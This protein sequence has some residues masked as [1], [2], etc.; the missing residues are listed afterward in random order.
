MSVVSGMKRLLSVGNRV[1]SAKHVATCDLL[2]EAVILNV[3]SGVYYGLDPVGARIWNL[4]GE[5]T[6]IADLI[7]NL[8]RQY[9]VDRARCEKEV[10]QLLER[11]LSEGLIE[12]YSDN[13]G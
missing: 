11:L 8:L 13:G 10:L 6:R 7:D 5:P 1:A 12:V 3:R 4:I 2:G 9:A